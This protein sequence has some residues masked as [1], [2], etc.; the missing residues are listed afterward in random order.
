MAD[1]ITATQQMFKIK[2]LEQLQS[3]FAEGA[4]A[5]H[6]VGMELPQ[7][8]G[9]LG[10]LN[11]VLKE[12][13]IAGS[14]M[15]GVLPKMG[16][17][18]DRL[19]FKLAKNARGGLDFTRSLINMREKLG[20]VGTWSK[21]TNAIVQKTFGVT[22][23]GFPATIFPLLDDMVAKE[24]K[25]IDSTGKTQ[26]VV[27]LLNDSWSTQYEILK[28]NVTELAATQAS[29]LAVGGSMKDL[30]EY[31]STLNIA[32]KVPEFRGEVLTALGEVAGLVGVIILGLTAGIAGLLIGAVVLAV[33]FRKRI[34]DNLVAIKDLVVLAFQLV[35][36]ELEKAGRKIWD[37]FLRG[38]RFAFPNVGRAVSTLLE[39]IGGLFHHSEPKWGPLRG[40]ERS[41]A[42]MMQ[43][44]AAGVRKGSRDLARLT[45]DSLG[46]SSPAEA[47]GVRGG[48]TVH[49]RV[50]DIVIRGD[51]RDPQATAR[52][53]RDE[54][55]ALLREAETA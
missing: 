12:G 10:T 16:D 7:T 51:S 23:A 14:T 8:L 46:G 15:I 35:G 43:T 19:G 32:M 42:L 54:L 55:L 38:L 50:G 29:Y 41:G 5:A 24:K 11:D 26:T 44:Y 21:A 25:V 6:G 33:V 18:A 3:G 28:N 2:D 39:V 40:L 48:R 49:L 45:R 22:Y 17:L 9:L 1:Q 4:S 30:N 53:V 36:P 52:A 31:L 13:A 20:D 37:Y 47:G 27:D 34:W